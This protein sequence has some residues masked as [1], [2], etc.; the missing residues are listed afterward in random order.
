MSVKSLDQGNNVLPLT[1]LNQHAG[2]YNT[3]SPTC[4]PHCSSKKVYLMP[5]ESKTGSA[6]LRSLNVYGL[7]KQ[8]MYMLYEDHP[9]K[10][11]KLEFSITLL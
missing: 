5:T 9:H 2:D 1:G 6:P 11:T 4:Y 10:H 8:N 3:T 7:K